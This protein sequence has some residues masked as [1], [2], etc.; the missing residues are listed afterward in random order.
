MA[1]SL[2]MQLKLTPEMRQLA[3]RVGIGAALLVGA[4]YVLVGMPYLAARKLDGEINAA[5]ARLEQQ[6]T[7][8]PAMQKI[9][10]G[11]NNA[12]VQA[13][14]PPKAEPMP[15]SRVY[16]V[17]EEIGHMARALGVEP[18]DLTLN[19]ASLGQD[20]GSIQFSGV[21]SGDMDA[22][23]G[24]LMQLGAMASLAR[25]ERVEIRAVDGH[26]EMMVQLRIALTN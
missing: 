8:L 7:L 14:M 22:V 17:P 24:L 25:M 21:F 12:T 23:R 1:L 11:A 20:P 10:V 2:N 15:R 19:P 9:M 18:L 16:L 26:L 13:L 4:A 6:K 5:R 3:V